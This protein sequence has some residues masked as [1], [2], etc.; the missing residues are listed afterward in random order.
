[1]AQIWADYWPA[2]MAGVITLTFIGAGFST[3]GEITRNDR[4]AA[5]NDAQ[6][7]WHIRHARQDIALIAY[8]LVIIAFLLAAIL[9]VLVRA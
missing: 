8:T 2:I 5:P 6:V 9:A 7:R 3:G 4:T 1:M